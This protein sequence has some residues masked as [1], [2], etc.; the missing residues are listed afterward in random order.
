[1]DLPGF[2]ILAKGQWR[3]REKP[4]LKWL[5]AM[6]RRRLTPL[7]RLVFASLEDLREDFDLTQMPIILASRFGEMLL[8][9]KLIQQIISQELLSPMAF[10][11]SV[12]NSNAGQLSIHF[13]NTFLI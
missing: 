3:K 10:S 4:H 11:L 6:F 9:I 13:K 12:H 7:S 2:T 5:P 1:M 8:S